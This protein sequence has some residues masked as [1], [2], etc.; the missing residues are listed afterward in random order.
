MINV[1]QATPMEGGCDLYGGGCPPSV[2]RMTYSRVF[3]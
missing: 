2:R 3:Y 1:A